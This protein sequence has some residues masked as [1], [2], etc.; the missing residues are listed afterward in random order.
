MVNL[1]NDACR[2]V[3][4]ISGRGSNMQTIVDTIVRESLP[5]Q[6][7]AVISNRADAAGLDWAAGRGLTTHVVPH[8]VF[9]SR[10]EFD[11]ALAEVID[12]YQPHYVL[13]AGFMRVLT[14]GFVERY[15]GRLINIHPSLLPSFPGL[16]THQQALVDGVQ[17]HG[18]TVHF[19]TAKLDHGPIVAQGIV[20]VL[21]SDEPDALSARL[22]NVEHRMYA[23]VVR[24]LAQGRVSLDEN[25]IVRVEGV[26]TRAFLPDG[27]LLNPSGEE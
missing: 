6:V 20:P 7:C 17:W 22:L 2:L 11:A 9:D 21:A 18:C 23:Q 1:Q 3:I 8:R 26:P 24:W 15:E 27:S 4:L 5:A 12:Q 10:Q 19:V 16:H 14:P 25:Q 13:L